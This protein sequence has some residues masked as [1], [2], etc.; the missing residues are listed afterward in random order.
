MFNPTYPKI[1]TLF[2]REGWNLE[3][4]P[5]KAKI[6]EGE[7]A[8]PEFAAIDAWTVTEKIDGTNIRIIFDRQKNPGKVIL[9]GRTDDAQIPAT[10]INQLLDLFSFEKMN[11]VF[12]D[13][14]KVTIFGEGVG[15]KIQNDKHVNQEPQFFL[16]DVC[17]DGWWLQRDNV[18]DVGKQFGLKHYESIC[19]EI[20]NIN[21]KKAWTKAEIVDFVKGINIKNQNYLQFRE[22]EGVVARSEPMMMFRDGSGPIMFK[23]KCKDFA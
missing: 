20:L 19:T 21:N 23:L 2:K 11:E 18:S 3:K 10:M 22:M 16:F 5:K 12:K 6:I 1:N 17:C 13:N 7:Y 14:Q 9:G 15:C 4:R 8:C